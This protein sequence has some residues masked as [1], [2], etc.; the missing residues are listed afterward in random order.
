MEKAGTLK[1]PVIPVNDAQCKYMFDNR[2]GTGQSVWDGIM[3]TTKPDRG[4]QAGGGCG[5]RLVRKGVAKRAAALGAR[6]IVTEID[7]IKATEALM[8]GF[9]VM[10]MDDAAALGDIF[11]TVTGCEDVIVKRHFDKM[12]D[13]VLLANA[14]TF[15]I[16]RLRCL[17]LVKSAK[18]LWRC[19]ITS[20]VMCRRTAGY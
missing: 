2:Y 3:R 12:K 4:R 19:A 13:G 8:D 17:S 7:H 10:S 1:I 14:V 15:L 9:D 5:L 18:E 16:A 20:R 11:V 6:V